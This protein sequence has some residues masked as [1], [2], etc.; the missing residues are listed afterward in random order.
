MEL[1]ERALASAA[2]LLVAAHGYAAPV[3]GL[4]IDQLSCGSNCVE[5]LRSA[6]NLIVVARNSSGAI[7]RT[8]SLAIPGDARLLYASGRRSKVHDPDLFTANNAAGDAAG[9]CAHT[10]GI[11]TESSVRTY[12]TPGYYIFYTYTFVFSDGNLLEISVEETR[13]ARDFVN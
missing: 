9:A 13:T 4:F 1:L 3:P 7:F 2:L 5:S 11:C 6:D 12:V 10:P 8:L